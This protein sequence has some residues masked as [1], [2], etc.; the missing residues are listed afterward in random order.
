MDQAHHEDRAS[1]IYLRVDELTLDTRNPRLVTAAAPSQ[2]SLLRQLYEQE[3]LDELAQSFV[4]N[5]YFAEE[6]L[7]V[8]KENG[9]WVVV[10]GN[11]RL[12][13]LKLL[14]DESLRADLKVDGWPEL[15]IAQR[16]RIV[17]VPCVKYDNREEVFPFL[18]F[19]HITGAKKWAPFQ[20]ARFIAQLIDAGR[21]LDEVEDLIGDNSQTVKKLYQD[22]IVFNQ[23]KTELDMP[24]RPIRDRFS[25]LEVTLGQRPIKAFLGIPKT[26]P[27]QATDKLVPEEKLDAL[28]EVV[29]WVFGT[30]SRAPILLES[31]AI[32]NRLAPVL[33][34]SEATDRLRST[35]DL[36]SAYE[37]SAGEKEFLL[38][39]IQSAERAIRDVSGLVSVYLEDPDVV[40]GVSRLIQLAQGLEKLV[41]EL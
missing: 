23:I 3:S 32:S 15:S 36:E 30:P 7:V 1:L 37:Y 22:Y 6:P 28:E 20:K 39:K 29:G 13:T 11:R 18:G 35:G 9:E 25:L 24:E 31:R 17:E 34:S 12:A 14:L 26:L 38:K 8:V 2:K 4:D 40:R 41:D 5:G 16:D 27:K 33:A 10:E 19:R 21:S